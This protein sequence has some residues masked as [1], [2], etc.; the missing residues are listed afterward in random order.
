VAAYVFCE[1]KLLLLRR[2]NPPHTLAPP[3]GRLEVNEDPLAGLHREIAEETGLTIQVLGL[4]HVWFGSVDGAQ[5]P[6]LCLNFVAG[7]DRGDVRLSGEHSAF[8]WVTRERIERGN[9]VTLDAAGHGY[10]HRDIVSAF[11]HFAACQAMQSPGVA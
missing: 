10:Q 2:A 9:V 5:P 11:D 1:G 3:G 4:A 6:L 7:S 8:M